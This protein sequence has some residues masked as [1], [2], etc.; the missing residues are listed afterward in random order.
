MRER[1]LG[2]TGQKVP[3]I[4]VEGDDLT[5]PDA[6]HVIVGGTTYEALVLAELARLGRHDDARD[7]RPGERV[8]H[9]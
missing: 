1:W 6:G 4:A 3:E 9:R 2:A 8:C 7:L 5:L